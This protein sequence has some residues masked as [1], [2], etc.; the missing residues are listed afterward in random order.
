MA[1][2]LQDQINRLEN[3][4][5][6]QQR[7]VSD[8]S[9][10][11]RTPLTTI[12]MASELLYASRDD[13][14]PA[15][16]RAVELLQQQSERFEAL[17]NDLLEISRLDAGNIK[18]E[19][20]EVHLMALCS[21]VIDALAPSIRDLNVS[22]DIVA[23]Q[24]LGPVTCDVRR[25]ERVVRNL[26]ANAIEHAQGRTVT[27]CIAETD[28]DVAVVVRDRGIG[29]KP[30]E[31]A[32]VF[33]RFWRADPSRQRTLGG[34]GLGLSISFEDARVHAGWLDADGEPDGGS[35]FRLVIPRVFGDEVEQAPLPLALSEIDAW[36][37][38]NR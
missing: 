35:A 26:V 38:S 25:I 18:L 10:E 2:S 33:N 22:V 34:T 17:L 31:A 6:M 30:G 1:K 28:T 21:R 3:L 7:F 4:S 27:V 37:E 32:L 11:L 19:L 13:F 14:D 36:I 16:A 20:D 24:S 29:L 23:G 15:S 5:K 12:R 8:V 9:H